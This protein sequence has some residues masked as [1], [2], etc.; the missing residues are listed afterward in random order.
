M[1]DTIQN[2]GRRGTYVAAAIAVLLVVA[3]AVFL[4]MG[5]RGADGQ[6]PP[7]PDSAAASPQLSPGHGG[8]HGHSETPTTGVPPEKS[9]VSPKPVDFGRVLPGSRPVALDIPA[10]DVHSTKI[11]GL[12]LAADG[13]IEVPRDPAS[14][15]WF[16]PG[17]SP[18]QLGPAVIAGHVD[19]TEGPAVFY[20]LGNLRPGDLVRV[21]RADSS[22][23]TFAIDRVAVFEQADFPT[24]QVYGLTTRRPELRLITCGGEYDP[25]TGYL[26]NV[27]AFGHLVAAR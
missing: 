22:V 6:P 9:P 13:S 3:G 5:A 16:T 21:T 1:T 7:L 12:E 2:G 18:G 4:V 24:R 23:A 10:I 8:S 26:D 17:P 19:S 25:E 27:V 20:E 11:V 15:G 14:P